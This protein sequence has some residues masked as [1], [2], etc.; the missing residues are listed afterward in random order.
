MKIKAITLRQPWASFMALDLKK[1]ETR[2]WAPNAPIY[3]G[4][5]RYKGPLAI[6][7]ASKIH[8]D[9]IPPDVKDLAFEKLGPPENWPLGK[10]VCVRDLIGYTANLR[11]PDDPIEAML[12]S[13]GP[14]RVAWHTEMIRVFHPPIPAKGHQGLW[15]WEWPDHDHYE[16]TP[17]DEDT[18][19]IHCGNPYDG[20]F[21]CPFCGHG[22]PLDTGEFDPIT[23]EE[24]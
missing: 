5:E 6:H 2:S 7:A 11:I 19:C 18:H 22:D 8:W 1:N 14:G 9:E 10:I 23:G 20:G 4:S 21:R 16:E 3:N 17:I 12:G 15:D 24:W 13:Y